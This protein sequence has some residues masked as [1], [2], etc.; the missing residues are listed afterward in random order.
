MIDA[1]YFSSLNT[2]AMVAQHLSFTAAAGELNIT[3]GAVSQQIR[4]LEQQL[5][6]ALFVRE[7]RK[8]SLTAEGQDF[9]KVVQTAIVTVVNRAEVLARQS[10]ITL[11]K[12]SVLPAFANKCLIPL[13]PDFQKQFPDINL[14]I[15][16]ENTLAD[17]KHGECDIAIRFGLGLYQADNVEKLCA[18]RIYPVCSPAL[19]ID[20]SLD[21][22]NLSQF[23]LIHNQ[24]FDGQPYSR[25][26]QWVETQSVATLEANAMQRGIVVTSP[27]TA[28]QLAVEGNGIAMGRHT[29]VQKDITAG[30]LIAPLGEGIDIEQSYYLL[31]Q[32]EGPKADEIQKFCQ[33]LLKAG[34]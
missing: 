22:Q 19:L 8:L 21:I 4:Q 33:W 10:Q 2:F 23:Q 14:H 20:K 15:L 28:I 32:N 24:A 31:S 6:F 13:L 16:E 3:Q 18:E 11:L 12:I 1:N 17:L 9:L 7:P 25:W 34:L 30:R 5:E 27:D 26:Q 29:L